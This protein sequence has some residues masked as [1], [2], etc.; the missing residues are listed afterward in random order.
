[1]KFFTQ[2]LWGELEQKMS[3]TPLIGHMTD[4]LDTSQTEDDVFDPKPIDPVLD[5]SEQLTGE[6]IQPCLFLVG[7]LQWLVTLGNCHPWTTHYLVQVQ[8]NSNAAT[9]DLW[10]CQ[11]DH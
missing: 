6:S 7:R 5:D 3:S 1:M 8:V 4:S 9:K 10:L 2:A 11:K